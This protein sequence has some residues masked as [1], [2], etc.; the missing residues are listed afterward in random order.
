MVSV[1]H[2]PLGEVPSGKLLIF[3]LKKL[4]TGVSNIFLGDIT[5]H[6]SPKWRTL[7]KTSNIINIT[8]FF[9]FSE[10]VEG[11]QKTNTTC[12]SK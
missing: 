1:R 12:N 2:V 9:Y 4:S 8:D 10:V 11:A 6:A 7:E 3:L 5:Y